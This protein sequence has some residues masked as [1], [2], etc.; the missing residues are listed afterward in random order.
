VKTLEQVGDKLHSAQLPEELEEPNPSCR[1][2]WQRT[3][4]TWFS[5]SFTQAELRQNRPEPT[6]TRPT[7]AAYQGGQE[8]RPGTVD[9]ESAW[10]SGPLAHPGSQRSTRIRAQDLHQP[11]HRKTLRAPICGV[12]GTPQTV[13]GFSPL[14]IRILD[15][16]WQKRPDTKGKRNQKREAPQPDVG[17]RKDPPE[18]GPSLSALR[19]RT[20]APCLSRRR[21][22]KQAR[23]TRT[24]KGATCP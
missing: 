3:R 11:D 10:H 19:P 13:P 6:K 23:S 9:H 18:H 5:G 15:P 20:K 22:R 8:A 17:I 12:P 24:D 1:R 2:W 4:K 16:N 21:P 14:A 7:R